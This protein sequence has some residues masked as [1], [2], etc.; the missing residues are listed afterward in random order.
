MKSDKYIFNFESS[1]KIYEF[2]KKRSI[3]EIGF[4]E[5]VLKGIYNVL[6]KTFSSEAALNEYLHNQQ[7]DEI[8]ELDKRM[9]PFPIYGFI[10]HISEKSDGILIDFKRDE[11]SEIVSVLFNNVISF[12]KR[13]DNRIDFHT[14]FELFLP[15]SQR[16]NF[17]LADRKLDQISLCCESVNL[18]GIDSL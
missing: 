11:P 7:L 16:Q 5:D 4:S 13:D 3:Q 8:I 14:V 6:G 18:V 17:L 2:L 15:E 10:H 1:K 12:S 9:L